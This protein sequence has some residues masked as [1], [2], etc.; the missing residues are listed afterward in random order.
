[1]TD[2]ETRL[3][4][5]LCQVR[6]ALIE[7]D[8]DQVDTIR[9]ELETIFTELSDLSEA[10]QARIRHAAGDTA[11]CLGAAMQGLRA[12]RRR[13]ADLSAMDRPATYDATG[14]KGRL[15]PVP[16]GRRV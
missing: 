12:A 13:V 1:M 16:Q 7:A 11:L 10:E 2:T 5:A 3:M 4:T 9:A 14:R 8:F 6:A 15:G